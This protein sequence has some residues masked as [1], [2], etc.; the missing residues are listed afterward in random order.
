M[1][2]RFACC[3]LSLIAFSVS[4]LTAQITADEVNLSPYGVVYNHLFYL[5]PDSYD[6]TLSARSFRNLEPKA[7]KEAAIRLKQILDGRGLYVDIN[8]LPEDQAY[9]DSISGE[10]LHV[11][12]KLEPLIYV[13]RIDSPLVLLPHH[14]SGDTGPIPRNVSVRNSS[15]DLVF[16]SGLESEHYWCAGL[17][18]AWRLLSFW[19]WRPCFSGCWHKSQAFSFGD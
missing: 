19:C 3:L 17:A 16:S 5:Q 14:C 7:A 10:Y 1:L 18:V 15:F 8:R 13:E 11:V 4:D 2:R 9:R 6:P 12:D